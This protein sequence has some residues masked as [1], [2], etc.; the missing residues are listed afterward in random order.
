MCFSVVFRNGL[1][2]VK[3]SQVQLRCPQWY[4]LEGGT[5]IKALLL[6]A[7]VEEITMEKLYAWVEARSASVAHSNTSSSFEAAG[8]RYCGVFLGWL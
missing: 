3:L 5:R 6:T 8:R 2:K 7:R 4:W 1:H